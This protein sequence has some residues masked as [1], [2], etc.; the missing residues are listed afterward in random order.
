[1]QFAL[2]LSINLEVFIRRA[3][4][5]DMQF[6]FPSRPKILSDLDLSD[7]QFVEETA[8]AQ[9]WK[10]IR[11]TGGEAALKLYHNRN[12]GNDRFGFEFLR[13]LDGQAAAKVYYCDDQ[14]ALIEWLDGPSLG[15][16]TRVGRDKEAGLDLVDVANKLQAA[17]TEVP[18]HVPNLHRL[19]GSLHKLEIT[20][21][22]SKRDAQLIARAQKLSAELLATQNDMCVLHGDLHHDNIRLSARGYCAFDAR[23][24]VGERA[25]ELANAFRNPKGAREIVFSPVRIRLLAD[26]WSERFSVDRTRLLKWAAAKCALSIAWR[27][28]G[29]F[30]SDDEVE[31]MEL[32]LGAAQEQT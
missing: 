27:S 22:V 19:F 26:M 13:S 18:E 28:K 5:M 15:D 12:M 11:R 31:L 17:Q 21:S 23:G 4:E 32:L 14:V 2:I 10:V 1:M 9:I 30:E 16:M 8:I 7:P 6:S 3:I 29:V 24:V 25:F 20:S